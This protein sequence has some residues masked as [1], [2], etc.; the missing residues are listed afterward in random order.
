MI[1]LWQNKQVMHPNVVYYIM[2]KGILSAAINAAFSTCASLLLPAFVL[3]SRNVVCGRKHTVACGELC[4][5]MRPFTYIELIHEDSGCITGICSDATTAP[6]PLN[7]AERRTLLHFSR[8]ICTH[9]A[10]KGLLRLLKT[11]PSPQTL[12]LR[13]IKSSM[14]WTSGFV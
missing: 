7:Y 3:S 10:L 13:T 12:F 5:D 4:K 6:I 11:K 8:E 2:Q 14:A 9:P 1:Y